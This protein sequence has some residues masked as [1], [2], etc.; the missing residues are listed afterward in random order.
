MFVDQGVVVGFVVV[1]KTPHSLHVHRIAVAPECRGKGYGPR[2]LGHVAVRARK[3]GV[4]NVTL[5]VSTE[6]PDALRFYHRLGFRS[7]QAQGGLL[8]LIISAGD[9]ERRCRRDDEH[10]SV[11]S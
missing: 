7:A 11:E 10:R 1:S 9:L 4:P 8:D 2:L 3:D 5:R 6:N